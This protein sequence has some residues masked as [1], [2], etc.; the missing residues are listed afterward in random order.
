MSLE[1]RGSI[2]RPENIKFYYGQDR[3]IP[4]PLI[5][6]SQEIQRRDDGNRSVE[7]TR[8]NLQ[9]SFVY[10]SGTFEQ[11]WA[12]GQQELLRIFSEDYKELRIVAGAGNA[13]LAENTV[14]TGQIYPKINSIAVEP[15]ILVNLLNYT[16]E[17]ESV[18]GIDN[19]PPI[20]SY[21]DSWQF[22]EDENSHTITVSHSVSAQGVSTAISGTNA[23]LHALTFVKGKLGL[24][25]I[26]PFLP[27][28][29]EPNASGGQTVTIEPISVRRSES[30]D[31]GGGSYEAS[32]VF[33]VASGTDVTYFDQKT[34]TYE[35]DEKSTVKITINGSV[36]GLGRANLNSDFGP[37]F[38]RALSAFNNTVRPGLPLYA[39][40]VYL[41]YK[42]NPTGSGLNVTNP[43]TLSITENR[44][45]GK[46]DY[47]ISYND[48][49]ADNLPSGIV[50]RS[51]SVNK[52]F[53]LRLFSS[54]A[55][56]YRGLG[57]IV[58]DIDTTTEGTITITCGATAENTGNATAD[59]NRAIQYIEGELNRLRPSV[60]DFI[61][62][63]ISTLQQTHSDVDLTAQANLTYTFVV[64][65]AEAP[66]ASG[67][68]SLTPIS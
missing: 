4:A 51:N 18:S 40:G 31:I 36:Q 42:S 64:D 59:T 27:C 39:S 61:D 6:F 9:G 17:L 22:T 8:W 47:S 28:F 25:N 7:I 35:E 46:I 57:N 44:Y 68:I 37:G 14:I 29:A 56:P 67:P 66:S 10:T 20:A 38:E 16:V 26:P 60:A 43:E 19:S 58:Q 2:L 21:Q 45:T 3:L 11:V 13:T 1:S 63:R 24:G 49:P 53:A 48:D 12:L 52:T 30:I 32:E 62:L 50:E 15:D 33:V 55:I 5:D 41:R 65:R 23:H 34:A 54:H